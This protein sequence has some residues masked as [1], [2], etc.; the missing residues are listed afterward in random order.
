MVI[1][2][3]AKNA[4]LI[5]L[6][7]TV[8]YLAVYMARNVLSAVQSEMV[9]G[10]FSQGF[11][12]GTLPSV[13]F[14]CYAVGQLINGFIGERIKARY[15]MSAG[16]LFAGATTLIFSLI[17]VEGSFLAMVAY[18]ATGFFLAMIYGPMTKLVS[19]NTEPEHATRC[20]LG[21]T[22][23]SFFGSPLAGMLA[24]F[25]AWQ[26]VFAVSSA[27]L[28]VM[29][30]A[31]F[32][33]VLLFEKKG[34][35]KYGQYKREKAKS[36]ESG[37]K[38]L[39]K[40]QI[41][42]FAFIAMITSIIRIGFISMLSEYFRDNLLFSEDQSKL[43]YTVVTLG[44]SVTI[45]V[46]AFVYERL[47]RN[48]NLTILLMFSSAVC[49]FV[50]VRVVSNPYADIVLLFFAIMSSNSAATMLWSRYC[51]SLRDT[52]MV[53]GATGFLDFLGY[54]AAAIFNAIFGNTMATFGW[55][56]LIFVMI[57]L[58]AAGVLISLPYDKF[59]KKNGEENPV[60]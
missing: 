23:A 4:F 2:K 24:Y 1:S 52:G 33:V 9:L 41:V 58:M 51:P 22:F 40:R 42:K 59:K 54:M 30:V 47:H 27:A 35:V 12:V 20:S 31:V 17:V 25:F 46:V 5:G 48:M 3:K 55:N 26:T 6:L 28:I 14:G 60:Q 32:T 13:S 10:D 18:G 49:F 34:I 37:I 15:M 38:I 57:G 43:I 7:C 29:S 36:S 8:A 21:Y 11:I 56:N 19:E 53:S 39:L 50:A 16:L 44:L 45:F